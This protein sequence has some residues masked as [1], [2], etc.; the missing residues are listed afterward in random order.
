MKAALAGCLH[1]VEPP[2][3]SDALEMGVL[4]VGGVFEAVAEEA[5]EGDVSYPDKGE[6]QGKGPVPDVAQ[7]EEGEGQHEN[8][9]EVV[10]RGAEAGVGEV[11]DHEEVGR[12][13]EDGEEEPA[14]VEVLVS[15]EGEG[16]K[17]GFFDAEEGG[18]MGEHEVLLSGLL[19]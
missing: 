2:D 18:W 19:V 12:E 6:S 11:A 16:E 10:G 15:E 7:K 14:C 4:E 5:V 17:D 8:V 13:E 9:G 1:S 3:F